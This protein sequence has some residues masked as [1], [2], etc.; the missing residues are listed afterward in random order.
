VIDVAIAFVLSNVPTIMFVAGF[1][2]AAVTRSPPYFP[3]RLLRWLLLSTGI[4]YAWAG[5]FHIAF[6]QIAAASIGWKVSPFQFEIGVAD[7]SIGIVAIVSFWRGLDFQAP[8]VGY[9]SLFSFGVAYGHVR[10]AIEAGDFSKNN[11]GILL[12]ITVILA[13]LLPV[14]YLVARREKV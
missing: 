4:A 12:V 14:L 9:F 3:A 1:I 5:F 10:Q 8:I 11:F 13:A 6:P 7:V 2:L